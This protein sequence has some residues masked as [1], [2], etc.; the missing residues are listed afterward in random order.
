MVEVEEVVEEGEGLA[1]AD[2]SGCWKAFHVGNIL[3]F[4][5]QSYLQT[6]KV[7]GEGPRRQIHHLHQ[8]REQEEEEPSNLFQC[9]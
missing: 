1:V 3:I 6:P 5:C 9:F 4:P 7:E 8:L 2:G